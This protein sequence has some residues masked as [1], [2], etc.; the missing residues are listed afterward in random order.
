MEIQYK[1]NIANSLA[2]QIWFS[3]I[4]TQNTSLLLVI[5]NMFDLLQGCIICSLH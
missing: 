2:K 3:W 1:I 4:K 5:A